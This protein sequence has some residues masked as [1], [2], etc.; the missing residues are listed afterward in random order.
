MAGFMQLTGGELTFFNIAAGVLFSFMVQA[1]IVVAVDEAMRP[2]GG[3]RGF[4]RWGIGSSLY[5]GAAFVSSLFSVAFYFGLFAAEDFARTQF[6]RKSALMLDKARQAQATFSGVVDRLDKLSR[7]AT[8]MEQKER[9]DG[10]T[11]ANSRGAGAGPAMEKRRFEAAT[12][13]ALSNE[14]R[15]RLARIASSIKQLDRARAHAK[16]HPDDIPPVEAL[17]KPWSDIRA[18]LAGANLDRVLAPL[19]R[20]ETLGFPRSDP[21]YQKFAGPENACRDSVSVARLKD[22]LAQRVP[23]LPKIPIQQLDAKSSKQVIELVLNGFIDLLTGNQDKTRAANITDRSFLPALGFGVLVDLAILALGLLLVLATKAHDAGPSARFVALATR[24]VGPWATV[25]LLLRKAGARGEPQWR[26]DDMA[27][28]HQIIEELRAVLFVDH[29]GDLWFITHRHARQHLIYDNGNPVAAPFRQLHDEALSVLKE[30][31]VIEYNG[32][33][34]PAGVSPADLFIIALS[35]LGHQIIKPDARPE[36][37]V[38]HRVIRDFDR[39][40]QKA[41][42]GGGVSDYEPLGDSMPAVSWRRPPSNFFVALCRASGHVVAQRLLEFSA[43]D[44]PHRVFLWRIGIPMHTLRHW[45]NLFGLKVG[46]SS[47]GKSVTLMPGDIPRLQALA[48][49]RIDP[50]T[51]LDEQIDHADRLDRLRMLIKAARRQDLSGHRNHP[52]RSPWG[53]LA[54]SLATLAKEVVDD[55]PKL[56]VEGLTRAA[57]AYRNAGEPGTG[58]DLLELVEQIDQRNTAALGDI[59]L[60]VRTAR[61]EER[62]AMR[63][64]WI[65]ILPLVEEMRRL[66]DTHQNGDPELV[67]AAYGVMGRV[68]YAQK[69]PGHGKSE[70][71][72]ARDICAKSC[73]TDVARARIYLAAALRS[74]AAAEKQ[75]EFL[76]HALDEL[77][78][79]ERDLT[80][81]TRPVWPTYADETA[82]YCQY[83]RA[84]CLNAQERYEESIAEAS[85][86][87][88]ACVGRPWPTLGLLRTRA[89]AYRQL[90]QQQQAEQDQQQMKLIG[91]RA[92][93]VFNDQAVEM[94]DDA[95]AGEETTFY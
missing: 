88:Q 27:D 23:K 62:V 65:D 56:G 89:V 24:L 6:M 11:C 41:P 81:L 68:L 72:T 4:F 80:T 18:A 16:R 32:A 54:D 25:R 60:L 17:R 59:I 30:L 10:R 48:A 78:L 92:E 47:L 76:Q 63:D 1:L 21:A 95:R 83:E 2:R 38:A 55:E 49:G 67:A 64:P 86:A 85:K 42:C 82:I 90:G 39:M 58:H 14:Y 50:A 66:V 34:V 73:Q 8:K 70:L 37:F 35:P 12:H 77:E 71:E 44:R 87:L 94:L 3:L 45:V 43:T 91:D 29:G 9:T 40:K 15:R 46:S 5:L 20:Y 19:V 93:G 84:R 53:F 61:L 13:Q 74:E 52:T 31:R 33:D 79:A 57:V 51:L 26:S 7:Y 22:V 75:P 36:H 69:Q 28:V